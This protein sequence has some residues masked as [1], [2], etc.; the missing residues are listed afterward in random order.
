MQWTSTL[1]AG[2]AALVAAG[3]WLLAPA[4][5][6]A[7]GADTT[8]ASVQQ[9]DLSGG[10]S[11]SLESLTGESE[12]P[13]QITGFGVGSY[14]YDGRT[15]ENTFAGSKLAVA[16]FRELGDSFWFFGQLTT[17][18]SEEGGAG[19][20]VPTEIEIDNFL[21][22]FTP[23][24]ATNVS[25]S[26]GKFDTPIGFERDDEP[27]NL[28]PT[29]SFNFQYARPAKMVGLIGRWNLTPSV[30]LAGWVGNGWNSQ[31]D[32][33]HGKTVGLRVG[34]RPTEHTSFGLAGLYGPEG[35][36]GATFDRYLLTF[37]YALQPTPDV[38]VAGEANYGGNRDVLANGRDAKW[39]GGLLT[40]FG[41]FSRHF[42]TTLRG[43]VFRDRDGART[44]T[45]QTME[46]LTLAPTYLL[47]TGR[48]G[49]FANVEHTTFRIPRFQV[50]TGLR[51]DHS[52][53]D[54]FESGSG[55]TDWD[56]SYLAEL[57]VTF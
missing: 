1:G 53:R 30:D 40:L 10:G 56:I 23:P 6:R 3:A 8:K 43:E 2:F 48:E 55:A 47:G 41:R 45:P 22:N 42:G 15:D 20:E 4:G 24:G 33:N 39:Y 12:T 52:N 7:Q 14:T 31:L 9:L 13:L 57:V 38:I 54:V 5:L 19:G 21:V 36:Q 32:P 25:L 37:D 29:E 46:S 16:L 49:I 28:Q 35:E 18:L 44:G 34:T 11:R 50:R 17:A 27:L 51:Y 26:F